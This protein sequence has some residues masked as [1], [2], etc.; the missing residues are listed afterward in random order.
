MQFEWDEAK[1]L[2]NIRKHG[3]DFMDAIDIFGSPSLTWEDTR[4][5]YDEE[6]FVS[7]GLLKQIVIVVVYTYPEDDTIRIISVRKANKN[8]QETFFSQIQG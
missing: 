8:E 6:R 7:I 1:R 3:I 5:E 4:Y 2:I